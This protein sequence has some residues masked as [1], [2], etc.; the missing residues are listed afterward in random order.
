MCTCIAS[1]DRFHFLIPLWLN[2]IRNFT[3]WWCILVHF[4][5]YF[6]SFHSLIIDVCT[7]SAIRIS[8]PDYIFYGDPMWL[9]CSA[10]LDFNQIYSIKWFKDNQEMYRFITSN[11]QPTTFYQTSGIMIDVSDDSVRVLLL[12]LPHVNLQKHGISQFDNYSYSSHNFFCFCFTFC[13]L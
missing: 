12:V 5:I 11:Q 7:L 13:I 9:N 8:S 1:F 2:S 6:F 10:D 4:L 3:I